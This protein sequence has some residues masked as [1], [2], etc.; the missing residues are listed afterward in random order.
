MGAGAVW[1]AIQQLLTLLGGKLS[2]LQRTLCKVFSLDV[3]SVR[4]DDDSSVL[5]LCGLRGELLDLDHAVPTEGVHL[6]ECLKRVVLMMRSCAQAQLTTCMDR[7]FEGWWQPRAA[8]YAG[9]GAP[10]PR[11][12]STSF[13]H[14][15]RRCSA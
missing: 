8:Q 7:A 2:H 9:A 11:K 10:E 1:F 3:V 4:L 13:L 5:G 12:Q 15:V 14:K 6:E